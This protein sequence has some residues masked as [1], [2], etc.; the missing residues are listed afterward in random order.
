MEGRVSAVNTNDFEKELRQ[1]SPLDD[2]A[3][4]EIAEI[5]PA[6]DDAAKD[7]I[8][9]LCEKKMRLEDMNT[10]TQVYTEDVKHI[11]RTQRFRPIMTLAACLV[12]VAGIGGAM[13]LG[14]HRPAV[15]PPVST[16]VSDTTDTPTESTLPS[17]L[18]MEELR[19]MM[20][21]NVK[22][23]DYFAT[24]TSVSY[25]TED[26]GNSTY[27]VESG[28]F[29]SY[30]ELKDFVY[31]TFCDEFANE[32]LNGNP[33]RCAHYLEYNGKFCIQPMTSLD[34]VSFLEDWSS[35]SITNSEAMDENTA[36]F[37]VT[38]NRIYDD[39][40]KTPTSYTCMAV[41][42]SDGWRLE[43]LYGYEEPMLNDL[44]LE[45]LRS[46]MDQNV[47]C[48]DYFATLSSI[49]Y[50][51]KDLG[52]GIYEVVSDD[53]SSYAE[54]EAYVYSTY[55]DEFA[56]KLLTS[57]P[58]G[59]PLYLEYDGK[60]CMRL[61]NGRFIDENWNTYEITNPAAV[62]ENTIV[63]DVVMEKYETAGTCGYTCKAIR[64]SDGW[65]LEKLYGYEK[66]DESTSSDQNGSNADNSEVPMDLLMVLVRRSMMLSS[67]YPTKGDALPNT[68]LYEV[69][70]DSMAEYETYFRDYPSFK[71]FVHQLYTA[72][73][74]DWILHDSI[75]KEVDGK[76]YMDL[77]KAAYVQGALVDWSVYTIAVDSVVPEGEGVSC[78]FR[79]IATDDPDIQF[80]DTT[81]EDRTEYYTAQKTDEFSGWKI[82]TKPQYLVK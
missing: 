49:R 68:S 32:L 39:G 40:E 60:L 10:T 41:R 28:D 15:T 78:T 1:L 72:E 57:Y 56:N 79:A 37:D 35:Y 52:G 14:N 11:T 24:L 65:R 6:L 13:F 77:E 9:A 45:D 55:C 36:T 42:E 53:F 26:L 58:V 5:A 23:L 64:E 67:D 2:R 3:V 70:F 73:V 46:M 82:S 81:L 71:E 74:A 12:L 66:W 62:D 8:E 30:A 51:D 29:A 33:D 54:L 4:E 63:F 47:K 59:D 20:D 69:D 61:I 27:E 75:Y 43:K 7:R 16:D 21:Q 50:K 80:P 48:L 76:L 18:S 31:S 34:G 19:S 25:K 38:V 22:C 44:T 17:D